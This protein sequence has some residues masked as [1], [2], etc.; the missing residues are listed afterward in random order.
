MLP[1]YTVRVGAAPVASTVTKFTTLHA[2]S[3]A[4]TFLCAV[5]LAAASLAAPLPIGKSHAALEVDGV[6]IDVYTYKPQNYAGRG[7]LLTLHGVGRN[8]AGYRDHAIPIADRHGYLVAAPLFDRKRFPTWRYQH[9]GIVR[10]AGA[11]D[12]GVLEALPEKEW[13][14]QVFIELVAAIRR[15]EAAPE[16]PYYM[17][18]HSG[19][20][21]SLSRVAALMPTGSKRLVLANPGTYLWPSREH[22]FPDGFGGLPSQLSNDDALRR[23]LAQPLTL[24]LGT[25][26]VKQ[27]A[28]LSMRES[29]VAQGANRYQRG[30]NAYRAAQALANANGWPFNWKLFEVPDVGHSAARM[31]RSA[32]AALALQD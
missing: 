31:F 17:L 21:Q 27:D 14:G 4:V 3:T 18:G 1:T 13:I 8:A 2:A 24:L 6:Q 12:T 22:R 26:D 25:A 16:L 9:G 19:G 30:L 10:P 15:L 29:V 32:E 11:R 20:A 23:Y 7:V 28:D 5:V